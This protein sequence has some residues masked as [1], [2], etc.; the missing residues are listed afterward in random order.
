VEIA[1]VAYDFALIV[2]AHSDDADT[3]RNEVGN[4]FKTYF[5]SSNTNN[6]H[7]FSTGAFGSSVG[8]SLDMHITWNNGE[9]SIIPLKCDPTISMAS[10]VPTYDNVTYTTERAPPPEPEA[11]HI[12]EEIRHFSDIHIG[13]DGVVSG[14]REDGQVRRLYQIPLATCTAPDKLTTKSGSIYFANESSG[15]LKASVPQQNGMGSLISSALES[16]TTDIAKELSDMIVTQHGYAA[17][18]KVISTVAE[19]LSL[20]ERL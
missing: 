3:I 5:D 17:N 18:T 7:T 16:S 2:T 10:G 14:T 1:A 15:D 19:M 13:E 9:Q 11:P 20:L 6:K 8:S 12:R 4:E